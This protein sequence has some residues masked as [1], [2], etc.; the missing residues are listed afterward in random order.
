MSLVENDDS[1]R[2][3][4]LLGTNNG[5]KRCVAMPS[6]MEARCGSELWFYFRHLWTKVHGIK[7]ACA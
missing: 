2:L 5:F 6:L 1:L 4:S 7:F 3:G